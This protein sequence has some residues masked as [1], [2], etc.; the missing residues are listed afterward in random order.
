MTNN[1]LDFRKFTRHI[2]QRYHDRHMPFARQDAVAATG[3][4]A[5][6]AAMTASPGKS[7]TQA[8]NYELGL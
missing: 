2:N 6:K 1:G 5:S 8:E 3:D 7:W 4:I